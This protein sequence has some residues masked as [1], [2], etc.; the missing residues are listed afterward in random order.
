MNRKCIVLSF[1]SCFFYQAK[2]CIKTIREHC[3]IDADICALPIG[4]SEAELAWLDSQGVKVQE[5]LSALPK[6]GDIPEYGYSQ[7]CRPFLREVFPGYDIYMWVDS[8]IRF[9]TKEAFDIYF[10][11]ALLPSNPIVIC[12][13]VDSSYC[14]VSS[15]HN[16]YSYHEMKNNRIKEV[17]GEEAGRRMHYYYNFN[18]GIWA[19]HAESSFWELFQGKLLF[20]LKH[21][22]NHMREQDA[23]NMAIIDWPNPAF[24]LP[25]T[26]NWL[27]A[28]S[29]PK[30]DEGAGRFVRPQYPYEPISVLHLICSHSNVEYNG[31]T[32]RW[33][34]LYRQRNMTR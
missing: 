11:A 6:C 28:V 19:L 27:C 32:I 12:Q 30:L 7:I 14:I 29:M 33:Y 20:A 13:E 9:V 34:D 17:Y 31:Q 18:S 4:G 5:D 1:D 8:D 23:M 3:S 25:A 16:V 22:F 2:E 10:S 21:P 15:P 26:M 24:V